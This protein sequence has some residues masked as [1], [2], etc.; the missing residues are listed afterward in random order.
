MGRTTAILSTLLLLFLVACDRGD[1]RI[2]SDSLA[3]AGDLELGIEEAAEIL[4]PVQGLPND[5]PVVE[6]LADF[7]VD[8]TL[9]ALAVNEEGRLEQIDLSGI[10]EQ[11]ETQELVMRLR[12][13][14]IEVDPEV[15]DDELE[16]IYQADRPGEQVRARH[17]LLLYP[18]G[19]TPDQRDSVRALAEELRDRAL[20]GDDFSALAETYSDDP[21][22]AQR[23]GDL[24]WFSRGTMVPPFEEAAFGLEVGEVSD[25]VESE[26]GLH[27]IKLD[28][29]EFPPLDD[30]REQL[31]FD[32]QMERT[33]QAESIFIAGI[34]EGANIQIEDDAVE[35]MREIAE[36]GSRSLSSRQEGQ[37]LARYDGGSYTRGEFHRYV[38]NQPAD[39]RQ[40]VWMAEDDQLESFLRDLTRREL[41][42]SEARQR[43]FEVDPAELEAL[44]EELL[45]QYRELAEILGLSGL[46]PAEGQSLNETIRQELLVLMDEIVQGEADVYPLDLLALPL[47]DHFGAAVSEAGVEAVVARVA[48]LRGEDPDTMQEPPLD[49]DQLQEMM[50]AQGIPEGEVPDSE[51]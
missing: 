51:D 7:W 12:D 32:V 29:R 35:S 34:E 28:D 6:A 22:S 40:Q 11:E 10:L 4:A 13:E 43:G 9:L 24:N 27:V 14:V 20:A 16:A 17:V 33:A 31:R 5:A 3:R 21:G 2:G 26:F 1:V 18:D 36:L 49:M 42:V 23:G 47:R 19:A 48:E 37:P 8:Y 25:V 45:A 41:L 30:I 15:T 39:F 44:R 50:D 38:M 46:S